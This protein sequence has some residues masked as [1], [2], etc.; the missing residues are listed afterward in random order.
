[1]TVKSNSNSGVH[2]LRSIALVALLSLG[3]GISL[4]AASTEARF[5]LAAASPPAAGAALIA[6]GG[7][8][9]G[10]RTRIDVLTACAAWLISPRFAL[11]F[12]QA[13]NVADACDGFAA[14]I[15]RGGSAEA[16]LVRAATAWRRERIAE[17][18]S[19]LTR[20][21]AAAPHDAWLAAQRLQIA[22]RLDGAALGSPD[23]RRTVEDDLRL[24][25]RGWR[26]LDPIGR[27][28]IE[29]TP[30]RDLAL[31][32]F[33][34]ADPDVVKRVSGA[35]SRAAQPRDSLQETQR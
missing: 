4:R 27:V 35:L 24:V 15:R 12:E 14:G 29:P 20:S 19:H 1:M 2:L 25:A 26:H 16:E 34:G 6:E 13:A 22:A 30:F 32:T 21:R 31:E 18:P 23:L 28:L 11:L 10:L 33:E 7:A 5:V 3:V 9:L 17:I 8:P